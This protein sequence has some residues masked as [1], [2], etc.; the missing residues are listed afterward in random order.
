MGKN[1]KNKDGVV[2]STNPDFE[3]THNQDEEIVTLPPQQ[4]DLRV[5]LDRRGGGKVV[6]LVTGFY[7]S[8]ADLEVLGKTLK[9]K[10]GVGGSVKDKEILIQGDFKEKVYKILLDLKYKVKKSGG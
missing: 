10:C 5:L 8:D 3:Y 6:T 7:G 1:K 9:T 4:Q 2:Y